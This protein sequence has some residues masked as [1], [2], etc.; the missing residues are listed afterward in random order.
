MEPRVP[1]WAPLPDRRSL[2]DEIIREAQQEGKFDDLEG[3]GRPVRVDPSPDAVLRDLL[4]EAGI[5][6]EWVELAREIER[7]TE[8]A[9]ALLARYAEEYDA[10]AARLREGADGASRSPRR[11]PL[12]RR[13]L[14]A[15]RT[16]WTGA[17]PERE[18]DLRTALTA[19]HERREV[20]LRRYAFMLQQ[21]NRKIRRYNEIVP[22]G[23][24]QRA[25]LPLRERL[26]AFSERFPRLR[27]TA[28]GAL[29]PA[30][31]PVP[32]SL[33]APSPESRERRDPLHTAAQIAAL[34]QRRRALRR[35]PPIG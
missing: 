5:V 10:T 4:K 30:F 20:V 24:R 11:E 21:A 23:T 3:K 25:L 14:E 17:G 27:V 19:F 16:L 18:I 28:D 7:L 34:R 9:A 8:E 15:L 13:C 33:L 31:S 29:A 12:V 32:E 26:E 6:P 35:P 1:G 22:V 2:V